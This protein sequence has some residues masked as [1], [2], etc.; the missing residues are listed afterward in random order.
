MVVDARKIIEIKDS[1]DLT[2][3]FEWID[4]IKEVREA[5]NNLR[6]NDQK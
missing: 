1:L 2:I 5:D 3:D 6:L 4:Y